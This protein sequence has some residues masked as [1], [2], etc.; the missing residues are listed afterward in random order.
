MKPKVALA[1]I[2]SA[3][4]TK[5]L[6][7]LSRCLGSVNGY[8]DEIFIQLNSRKGVPIAKEMR[9]LAEQFT[10]EVYT[11]TW[12]DN[13]VE[14]REAI[15]KKV[16]KKY[17]WI[18]WV[19]SD[20]VVDNPQMIVPSLAVMPEDVHGV[21]ILYDYL[22]D[23]F[24]NVLV[25]HWATRAI[26]N[27]GSFGWKSSFDDDE[28]AVHET[29]I[30]KRGVKAVA[31]NEWKVV[32][33]ATEQHHRESLIRNITLLEGMFERQAK[34]ERGVDPRIMFYLGTHY[35]DA[36]DFDKALDLFIEY[37]KNSGWAEER[38]EAHVHIGKILAGRG[39][40]AQAR[41]AFL[42]AIGEDKKNPGAYLGLAQL[43][44][45]AQRW[46]QAAAWADDGLKI[47]S[48][49]TAMVKF[50]HD[51]DLLTLKAQ[52]L[53]NLG[54]KSLSEALKMAQAALKLRPY[55][56]AAKANRDTIEKL[57]D[58]RDNLRAAA[59]LI[60]TLN[61]DKE[62]TK[63]LPLLDALPDSLSDS[64]VVIDTRHQYATPTRWPKRSIAI[65]VGHGPLG[66]W[67]PSNLNNGGLGGSEEAVVRLSRELAR[68]GW[69]VTVFGTPGK[70]AG[71]DLANVSYEIGKQL[72]SSVNPVQWKHYWEINHKDTFDVLISWRQPAF[73]DFNWKARKKYLWLHD[74]MEAEELTKE[75][76]KNV[77]KVIYVSKYHSQRPENSHIKASKKLASGN[78]ITPSDFAALDNRQSRDTTR[79]IYM[80]ANE[81]GLRILLDIWPEVKAAVPTATL[82]A[83]YGWHSFDAV[84]R[85][86]PERMAWKATMVQRMKELKGVTER[87]R[88]GQNDLNKEIFKAGVFAYPSFFPEVNCITAQKAQAGGAWPVTSNFAALNDVVLFGDKIDMGKFEAEDI[89]KYKQALIHRLKNPPTDKERE[90]MMRVARETFDW[91]NTA[92]QWNDEML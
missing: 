91:A 57:I 58:Y 49:I 77:T 50:N 45:K 71:E 59:R 81:R 30:A 44:S 15:F 63:I 41:N 29:L 42:M 36:Y 16:S 52:A 7:N 19:D 17:D 46:E 87:G 78:G 66:T 33:Q 13:F 90:E 27:N 34:S 62:E 64:S 54:G 56:P 10:K 24:G 92:R 22:K 69:R 8:V 5:E 43:E 85:D 2:V 40:T 38:S 65:Y 11:Y 79:C 12:T 75:R 32:H 14:A 37:L 35:V 74:V 48:K 83:Y 51:Y 4:D 21:Y 3:G 9:T 39:K 88:I 73:F 61:K 84:N 23:E 86:N 55:D 18:I 89:E 47:K 1:M 26:R 80:S 67:G 6:I 25:S 68:L 76:I 82:D 72:G 20:D 60:R 70:E 28:V 53:S 31:N